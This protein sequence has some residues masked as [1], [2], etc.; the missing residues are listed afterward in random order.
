MVRLMT[1]GANLGV[2]WILCGGKV[3][4]TLV[5]LVDRCPAVDDGRLGN[6]DRDNVS[7]ECWREL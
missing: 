3:G 4:T 2:S 6:P 5:A 7:T 1:V